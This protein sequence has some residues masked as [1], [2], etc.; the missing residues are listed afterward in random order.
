[1]LFRESD[2]SEQG[3]P[4][5]GGTTPLLSAPVVSADIA[6]ARLP[7]SV[8]A[9]AA[10]LPHLPSMEPHGAMLASAIASTSRPFVSIELL[11]LEYGVGP[12]EFWPAFRHCLRGFEDPLCSLPEPHRGFLRSLF[13]RPKQLSWVD[14]LTTVTSLRFDA[15][16]PPAD[17][18]LDEGDAEDDE[19]WNHGHLFGESLYRPV[20]WEAPRTR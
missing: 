13:R 18:L 5:K 20:P 10:I 4:G 2:I 11:D 7:Q 1:M 8:A 15:P 6:L 16:F 19:L 17:L 9:F 12:D 3:V 14:S